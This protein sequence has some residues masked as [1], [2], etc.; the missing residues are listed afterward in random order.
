MLEDAVKR[1]GWLTTK[2]WL[3][4][5][6]GPSFD[7]RCHFDL[8]AYEVLTLNHACQ[9]VAATVAH[10]TDLEA[11]R[12]CIPD[13]LNVDGVAVPYV[14]DFVLPFVPHENMGPGHYNLDELVEMDKP[15][16]IKTLCDTGKLWGYNSTRVP[17]HRWHKTLNVVRVRYF[18]AVAAFNLLALAGHRRVYTLG[19]DGGTRYA[20]CFDKQ[21]CLANGQTSFDIQFK[22]IEATVKRHGMKWINLAAKV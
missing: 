20:A 3:I 4:L 19:V 18:S 9:V 17:Q 15:H 1:I 16:G 14:P 21:H 7:L 12:E 10:F 22:E 13:T 2:P 5:G 8:D 11:F 6:K